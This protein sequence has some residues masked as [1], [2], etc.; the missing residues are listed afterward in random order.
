MFQKFSRAIMPY[1]GWLCLGL[2]G[3]ANAIFWGNWVGGHFSALF[4]LSA[5]LSALALLT[6]LLSWPRTIQNAA[7]RRGVAGLF[8]A[9][10]P[11]LGYL[12][13]SALPLYNQRWKLYLEFQAQQRAGPN[14][15]DCGTEYAE[16]FLA[17]PTNEKCAVAAYQA[18]QPFRATA[19]Y[20]NVDAGICRWLI[21]TPTGEV[22]L[23]KQFVSAISGQEEPQAV[24]PHC[25][26]VAVKYVQDTTVLTCPTMPKMPGEDFFVW[27]TNR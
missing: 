1:W 14:A 17:L 27:W 26:E 11:L 16:G 22:Y 12:A 2:G 20:I 21:G 13:I 4:E 15:V 3:I 6:G 9:S 19:C 8:F 23:Y 7:K 10:L 5:G 18:H 25:A 24:D